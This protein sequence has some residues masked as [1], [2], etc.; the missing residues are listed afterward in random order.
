[1]RNQPEM[2]C[3]L[4][5][6]QEGLLFHS[7]EQPEADL[8][9]EQFEWSYKGA[10]NSDSLKEAWQSVCDVTPAMRS[11]FTWENVSEPLQVVVKNVR[12][13]WHAHDFLD[14]PKEEQL[15]QWTHLLYED[16]NKV[17][18]LTKPGLQRFIVAQFSP[19]EWRF[20]WSSH[21]IIMDGWSSSLIFE[22]VEKA[23]EIIEGGRVS[24]LSPRPDIG[25]FQKQIRS[26]SKEKSLEYWSRYLKDIH[27]KGEFSNKLTHHTDRK[28][29]SV[30]RH[31]IQVSKPLIANIER[32]AIQIKSTMNG[33]IQGIWAQLCSSYNINKHSLYGTTLSGRSYPIK[34]LDQ[35]VGMFLHTV[36]VYNKWHPKEKFSQV[37][38]AI[39]EHLAYAQSLAPIS[40]GEAK[41]ISAIEGDFFDSLLVFE[42]YP[43]AK[44]TT[45]SS[46]TRHDSYH[47]DKTNYPLTILV[48]PG[49]SYTI[50][51]N[52]DEAIFSSDTVKQL[53]D[54]FL[55]MLNIISSNISVTLEELNDI[56]HEQQSLIQS[57]QGEIVSYSDQLKLTDLIDKQVQQRSTELAIISDNGSMT[58][59]EMYKK[60]QILGQWIRDR[61]QDRFGHSLLAGSPI[62]V[63]ME[64]SADLIISVLGVLYSGASYVPIDPNMPEERIRDILNISGANVLIYHD[65][66]TSLVKSFDEQVL[67]LSL[68]DVEHHK[69]DMILQ[70]YLYH[71]ASTCAYVIFTS[72]STGRPKGVSVSHRAIVNRLDWMQR[73]YQLSDGDRVLQKT[74]FT[75]DVSVWEIFWPLIYGG[76]I[77]TVKPGGQKDPIYLADKISKDRVNFLHFVPTM[78]EAFTN[79]EIHNFSFEGVKSLFCSGEELNY[80]TYECLQELFPRANIHNLYGPTEASVDVSSYHCLKNPKFSGSEGVPI[81]KPIQNTEFYLFDEYGIQTPFGVPGEL[82]ISGVGLALGYINQAN[83][84]KDR[85]IEKSI[86]GANHRLYR[87]GDLVKQLPDG[88]YQFLNRLDSQ[89]KLRGFRIELHEIEFHLKSID[90]IETAVALVDHEH[91]RLVA[92]IVA[93]DTSSVQE[94]VVIEKLKSK[95]PAYMIPSEIFFIESL[96]IS[97]SGKLD[98]GA[99]KGIG[100]CKNTKNTSPESVDLSVKSCWESVLG[101]AVEPDSDFFHSGGHSILAI[102][103]L[104]KIN[105]EF[106]VNLSLRDLFDHSRLDQ[107]ASLVTKAEKTLDRQPD[108]KLTRSRIPMTIEQKRFYF[109]HQSGN[110]SMY[111]VPAVMKIVGQ[112]NIDKLR[113]AL[114]KLCSRHDSLRFVFGASG[115]DL[116]FQVQSEVEVPF[117]VSSSSLQSLRQDL[118]SEAVIPFSLSHGPLMRAHLFQISHTSLSWL[119]LSFHHISV[120]GWS[121][122]ILLNELWSFYDGRIIEEDH[123]LPYVEYASL[124]ERDSRAYHEQRKWWSEQNL[125]FPQLDLPTDYPRNPKKSYKGDRVPVAIPSQVL[126]PL[127]DLAIDSNCSIYPVL[128]SAW[129]VLLYHYTKQEKICVGTS[130]AN[131]EDHRFASTVGPFVNSVP[132]AHSIDSSDSFLSLLSSVSKHLNHVLMNKDV[133]FEE[134]SRLVRKNESGPLF[135]TMIVLQGDQEQK[136]SSKGVQI[137]RDLIELPISKFDLTVDLH[138]SGEGLIGDIE[139]DTDLFNREMIA[140]MSHRFVQLLKSIVSAPD[141]T[142]SMLDFKT[143]LDMQLLAEVN[144]V[145]FDQHPRLV[146]ERIKS[147]AC[148]DPD[149]LALSFE[150]ESL[151][152]QQL[153]SQVDRVALHLRAL[154]ERENSQLLSADTI[155]A[156]STE[157]NVAWLVATLGILRAGAAYLPISIKEPEDRLKYVLEDSC[158]RLLITDRL[159]DRPLSCSQILLNEIVKDSD[160]ID[161]TQNL[162]I[163]SPKQLAYVIYTSGTSGQPK[164][165]MIEH[166]QAAQY[167]E[168]LRSYLNVDGPK[169]VD[170]SSNIAFDFTFTTSLGALA[171]GHHVVICSDSVRWSIPEYA[172]FLHEE[173]IQIT[174]STPQ[175]FRLLVDWLSLNKTG[176]FLE[177]VVLGGDTIDYDAVRHWLDLY[178]ESKIHDEYGPTETTVGSFHYEIDRDT[179]LP[180]VQGSLI[181]KPS[182]SSKIYILDENMDLCAPGIV[183][184]LYIGGPAVCRGYLNRPDLNQD[185]FCSWL[186]HNYQPIRIYKTGDYARLRLDGQVEYLGRKDRQVKVRGNR[187]ELG[188][189]EQVIKQTLPGCACHALVSDSNDQLIAYIVYEN[190]SALESLKVNLKKILPD[191]MIPNKIVLL[192]QFPLNS[193]GK[194]CVSK[195][196]NPLSSSSEQDLRIRGAVS[197]SSPTIS[198]L[199]SIWEKVLKRPVNS[200]NDNFFDLGGNSFGMI[201]TLPLILESFKLPTSKVSIVSLFAHPN[202]HSL[203]KFIDGLETNDLSAPR[204]SRRKAR[205]RLGQRQRG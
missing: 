25:L 69:T 45:S 193:N 107:F 80:Q 124:T 48:H 189:V 15:T 116:F 130:V 142:V 39:Q 47:H 101:R 17:Y 104:S 133:P 134:I 103:L 89:I 188:E 126:D 110:E 53:S 12:I 137:E 50:H 42:S 92:Y 197:S 135:T 29:S 170:C 99:L 162:P 98:I 14:L 143:G 81:G 19:T 161:S 112:V 195:L 90:C 63:M 120:D 141:S 88:N 11:F 196:P 57:H 13:N 136:F 75:F 6:L 121:I 115:E 84:T 18:D 167:I 4:T 164:G 194:I 31:T 145:T 199:I 106:K 144:E 128:L 76:S 102:R 166:G 23:Y 184:E 129:Y 201:Q 147:I 59:C 32:Q 159:I 181:G 36:P 72:G 198:A 119:S 123:S 160:S 190:T 182:A 185:L 27:A 49:E 131:R 186:D 26:M 138:T 33:V 85:F 205:S 2:V 62:A 73:S 20:C 38:K 8:Y 34:G 169:R 55:Y 82:Y 79:S 46:L 94:S 152:Y 24:E 158:A 54:H 150:N 93:S 146:L 174:K 41:A 117:K 204:T 7:V 56:P 175:L 35:M 60:S 68:N 71:D 173:R 157:R 155:I 96:P 192:D 3:K 77:V 10:I 118:R 5:P 21:H 172:Q 113:Q 30:L 178:P 200:I 156:I 114:N 151:T 127:K 122:D 95:L 132:L 1:M 165:V 37:A 91:A 40:L 16:R 187:V 140:R 171:L 9:I 105:R 108:E 179:L 154:Y 66:N 163:L 67:A 100:T 183:G 125:N 64:S 153:N 83:L 109:G 65:Q 87:T 177:N 58:Y 28:G 139:F 176:L 148:S 111:N 86:L 202:I 70:D 51:F 43:L 168:H 97:Q 203:A 74:S 78:A 61:Y 44:K 149:R 180:D 191:H 52:Y 22:D